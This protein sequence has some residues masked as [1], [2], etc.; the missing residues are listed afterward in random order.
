MTKHKTR[1][2]L[3]GVNAQLF[4]PAKD[5]QPEKGFD[6]SYAGRLIPE[7]GVH[8]LLAALKQVAEER[9]VSARIIGGRTFMPATLSSY[10][11]SLRFD[12]THPNLNVEFMGPV[13]PDRIPRALNNAALHVVPSVWEE[14]CGLSVIE[15]FASQ[16]CVVATKVGGIPELAENTRLRLVAPNN[17]AEL[18]TA[19]IDYLKNPRAARMDSM[20]QRDW[21]RGRSWE[22]VYSDLLNVDA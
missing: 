3:H 5:E 15:G 21:T 12:F 16:A 20:M 10:E 17:P 4:E 8:I 19:I 9:H 13:P 2:V 11:E 1:A 22:H 6:V 7:K 14:P 18:A